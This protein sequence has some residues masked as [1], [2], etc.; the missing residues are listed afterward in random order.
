[1]T[2]SDQTQHLR[3]ETSFP[4]KSSFASQQTEVAAVC[5]HALHANVCAAKVTILTRSHAMSN[6]IRLVLTSMM[7]STMKM[8]TVLLELATGNLQSMPT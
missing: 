4:M 3:K 6:V 8:N 1:M 7:V 2:D 5:M